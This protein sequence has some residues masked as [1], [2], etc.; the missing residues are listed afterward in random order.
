[1]AV[2][3]SP[4]PEDSPGI[5][6][7]DLARASTDTSSTE[8]NRLVLSAAERFSMGL[9]N[10]PTTSPSNNSTLSPS[11]NNN[12]NSNDN[13]NGNASGVIHSNISPTPVTSL[14]LDDLLPPTS[15]SSDNPFDFEFKNPFSSRRFH[16]SSYR[17]SL[18]S[19]NT[20]SIL[21][22]GGGSG[23]N[24]PT[25]PNSLSDDDNFRMLQLRSVF[26]KIFK[27][28]KDSKK[29]KSADQA[30]MDAE[31]YQLWNHL[32]PL[33][34]QPSAVFMGLSFMIDD[35]GSSVSDQAKVDWNMNVILALVKVVILPYTYTSKETKIKD[36]KKIAGEKFS[37]GS[38]ASTREREEKEAKEHKRFLIIRVQYGDF[39]PSWLI[40]RSLDDFV[41]LYE[42]YHPPIP[43]SSLLFRNLKVPKP[44]AAIR[45][46]LFHLGKSVP[47]AGS[48]TEAEGMTLENPALD[49]TGGFDP[50][51]APKLSGELQTFLQDMIRYAMYL[52]DAERMCKFLELSALTL[53]NVPDGGY[54]GKEGYLNV[55][56]QKKLMD[57]GPL[58][59]AVKK[60]YRKPVSKY[61]IVRDSYII[62]AASHKNTEIED[63][64]LLDSSFR[65]QKCPRHLHAPHSF[66]IIN[67]ELK[68]HMRAKSDHR[69]R[70]FVES[71]RKMPSLWKEP[72]RFNSFAP[73]RTN[74]SAQWLVDG[75]DYFWNVSKAMDMAKET[76]YILD[77][78]LSPEI[79]LRRHQRDG[80]EWS[81]KSILERKANEGVKI[82]I[83]MYSEVDA[84]LHLASLRAKKLLRKLC[85]ENIWVQ[86]H[87][88]NLKTAWWAHHEKLIVIDNMIAFLG[89]L[90]LCFG[91]WD[92][93]EHTLIDLKEGELGPRWPGQDYSNPR[94]KDFC[95]LSKP[96][97][98]SIDRTENPRMPWHD[99]G[100]QILGQPSRDVARHFIQRW[101]FLCRTKP[102]QKRVPFLLP[103]PDIH[104]SKLNEMG[105]QGTCEVQIL[106]SVSSWSIGVKD[107]ECSILTTYIAAIERAEHF[108]YIENQF[109]ITSTNVNKTIVHNGVGRALTD[110]I[111]KAHKANEKFRVIVVLPLVPGFEGG[112]NTPAATSVRMVM[113]SIYESICHGKNS[114]YGRLASAGVVKPH[115]YISFYGLRNWAKFGEKFITEQVYIHAKMMIVD[116]RI[117]IIGSANI[118]ERSMLGNR[119]SEIAAVVRDQD[120]IDSTMNGA[121]YKVSRFAHT[122]RMNLMTEHLGLPAGHDHCGSSSAGGVDDEAP[123]TELDFV[124]PVHP[125][126]FEDIWKYYAESNTKIFRDMFKC[127]PDNTVTDWSQY[128]KFNAQSNVEDPRIQEERTLKDKAINK[129]LGP[130][131]S[132]RFKSGDDSGDEEEE[133]DDNDDYVDHLA[134]DR[135]RAA[136][137]AKKA[138]AEDDSDEDED[139]ERD[140][141]R[142][143]KI[144][145]SDPSSENLKN[146]QNNDMRTD[147]RV[148]A[149]QR[150]VDKRLSDPSSAV[151][152]SEQYLLQKHQNSKHSS[153]GKSQDSQSGVGEGFEPLRSPHVLREAVKRTASA[154]AQTNDVRLAMESD[155]SKVQGH[156]VEWPLDFLRD[157]LES[158][159]FLY[160]KDYNH[161]IDLYT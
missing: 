25:S 137:A 115:K 141:V 52:P 132:E 90:D 66:D 158:Y 102:K 33:V 77:W 78:M 119:D 31:E 56:K 154:L 93:P 16:L 147:G 22:T 106:R 54:Q 143:E 81:L 138:L 69:R 153:G 94:I 156:L 109:F 14:P 128:K 51:A 118:N 68:F 92:T 133:D 80:M 42:S 5:P 47:T 3:V 63:V 79:L 4:I 125:A 134:K 1:M 88:P 72:K 27:R 53:A 113:L 107:P 75:R 64:I 20:S 110:R 13:N 32:K 48:E 116:D 44:P 120:Y 76:I 65:A 97:V 60:V 17:K 139:L 122:L 6:R 28:K 135:T 114:I 24:A 121:P 21:P 149:K 155:L 96:D 117:A 19:R 123:F 151:T 71:I 144:I 150:V 136:R 84:A 98:D 2:E 38:R 83:V 159:N 82:Y 7:H 140:R 37:K 91:R 148:T 145:H 62:V 129:I 99:V 49:N 34:Y 26:N 126:F 18:D 131:L 11:N 61:F 45:T 112:I 103:K 70:Q 12:R 9:K 130:T 127:I 124:D 35:K 23:S 15:P 10:R 57:E 161:P 95:D 41:R 105:L 50:K 152:S 101:N 146:T 111:I 100:L 86:R 40:E 29:G 67:S 39:L 73:V 36:T 104:L 89:G 142:D 30:A 59:N 46:R 87:G 157:E 43:E 108:I 74:V 55:V 58:T 8:P 85:P 160:P